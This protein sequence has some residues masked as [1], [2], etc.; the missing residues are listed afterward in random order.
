MEHHF[1]LNSDYIELNKLLKLLGLVESGGKANLVIEN[2]EV[3]LNNKTEL[4]K[5]AKL[6]KNDLVK[7][8]NHII[9]I[10]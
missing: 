3:Q 5:R 2:Q 4:R 6:V 1:E 10:Q 9:Y 8:Q 7:F